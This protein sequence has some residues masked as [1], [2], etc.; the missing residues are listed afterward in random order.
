M[1]SPARLKF[2]ARNAEPTFAG[3]GEGDG[4]GLSW[5]TTD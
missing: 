2:A 3:A 5:R 4:A 1:V